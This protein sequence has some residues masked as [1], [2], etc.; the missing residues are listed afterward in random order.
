[1]WR[2]ALV[3]MNCMSPVPVPAIFYHPDM[4][5][6]PGRDLVGRR[7]AGD[8]FL[9]GWLRH[10]TTEHIRVVTDTPDH[11][12]DFAA[13]MTALGETRPVTATPLRGGADFTD[14]GTIFFP[15]PGFHNAPWLRQRF[16]AARCSLVG[17]THTVST[18]RMIEGLHA[19]LADPVEPWDAIICTSR[20]VR[21]V[22]ARQFAA[23]A[24]Y[25][26]A[27]LGATRT[28]QPMLPVIPLGIDGA[29][30]VPLPGARARMRAAQGAPDDAVVVMTMGRLSVVE[31][32]NPWPLLLALE[33]VA[34][35]TRAKLHLW[36]VGWAAHP[37]EE[38]LHREAAAICPSVTV[39]I[40][41]G[42]DPDI[43]RN[44]R[45]AADIFSLPADSIQETFGLAPVEAMAA[46]LPVVVPDWDGFRDTVIHGETGFLVPTRMPP[47]GLGAVLA[48]RFADGTDGYLAHLTLVQ[49]HVQIDVPA[50][51][52]A[53]ANLA[54]NPALRAQMGAAGRA[55]VATCLDW[56]AVIPK[57]LALAAEL[58]AIR[59]TAQTPVNPPVNPIEID[60]FELYAQYPTAHLTFDTPVMPGQSATANALDAYDK[61]SG[62]ALY[63]RYAVSR[64]LA[65]RVAQTVADSH[66]TTPAALAAHLRERP[67]TILAAVLYLAKGDFLRLPQI[68]PRG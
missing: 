52:S 29:G 7:A 40:I 4:T 35:S 43:R 51:C 63:R 23:E 15:T 18:R 11:A 49:A 65:L 30:F 37:E 24:D 12:R 17:I 54:V 28:P 38:A 55:H 48:R 20:A 61:F 57:Y 68:A 42:R 34:R 19:M 46:G 8:G 58:A 3:M 13:Q 60:P 14:A 36:F 53:L 33:S 21:S 1:M 50:Y 39:R 32:A 25:L 56:S 10:V 6:G 41:D 22:L 47:P 66:P 44:I 59:A 31:K 27:R 45:A 16:G 26:R 62:R 5:E 2:P 64:D 67:A 9:R